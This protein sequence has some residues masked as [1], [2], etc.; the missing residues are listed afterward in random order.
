MGLTLM[1]TSGTDGKPQ[2]HTMTRVF[3]PFV[4]AIKK[5]TR[6]S[7]GGEEFFKAMRSERDVPFEHPIGGSGGGIDEERCDV[8]LEQNP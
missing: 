7:E 8:P 4:F 1:S 5:K 3:T 6:R 2:Q